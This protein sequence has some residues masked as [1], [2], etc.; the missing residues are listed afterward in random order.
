MAHS[1]K[2]NFFSRFLD[3]LSSKP[4]VAGVYL[5]NGGMEYV[6]SGK[7]PKAFAVKFPDGVVR[8]G[9]L[10]KKE[11]FLATAKKL[12]ELADYAHKRKSLQ[13]VVSLPASGIYTQ[14]FSVPN[15]DKEKLEE[16]TLLNLQML[17]PVS[18]DGAYMSAEIINETPDKYDLLGAFVE[19]KIVDDF[20][21]ALTAANFSPIA[22]EFPALSLTRLMKR[23][24]TP[25][26]HAS[27]VL[28]VSADGVDFFIVKKGTIY[29]D[30]FRS[31]TS[32]QGAEKSIQK[33][34]FT[35][36]IV[37]ETQKVSNFVLSRF[38]ERLEKVYLATPIFEPEI[39]EALKNQIGAAVMPFSVPDVKLPAAW[40][41]ALGASM[42]DFK[43]P[44][45]DGINLNSSSASDIFFE[46][47]S[48][49]FLYFWRKLSV[50][51]GVLF[52]A[53]FLIAYSFLGDQLSGLREQ[54]ENSRS[55]ENSGELA[56]LKEKALIF[57]NLIAELKAQP[58]QIEEW[59]KALSA[60][61]RI[62]KA[63]NVTV[64]RISMTSLSAPIA[65][66]A[67]ANDNN[68]TIA[69]KNALAA[70]KGFS[71]VEIPLLSIR[72]LEDRSTGFSVFF[73]IDVAA[74]QEK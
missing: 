72:E 30:Y 13:V 67:R 68:A 32:V 56:E 46:Q 52:I 10:Q 66:T 45:R 31:W 74:L 57:N 65:M 14:S 71:Q 49:S 64:D 40:Y 34:L 60:I 73:S 20:R 58:R 55:Q 17:S 4:R 54:F 19:K 25:D 21:L 11:D 33:D 43:D 1:E 53:A 36:T 48:M 44:E 18:K 41:P 7:E 61:S 69:F 12:Y 28:H 9:R 23:F 51:T 39:T 70:E 29:F 24:I 42:R 47:H 15:I 37:S 6:L 35:S 5:T 3:R 22:F 27:L 38:K 26:D 63:T 2:Q 16:S 62:A 8:D 50:L 59:A